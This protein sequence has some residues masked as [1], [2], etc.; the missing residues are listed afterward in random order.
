MKATIYA[1][2]A[3]AALCASA[4][5]A[6]AP[7]R[8]TIQQLAA[9]P[10]FSGF[11]LSPDGAHIAALRG[12]GEQRVIAVWGTD[13][14][15]KAPTLIGSDQMKISGVSFIKNDKLAVSFWQPY[16][17]RTDRLTK[18]FI[19]KLMITDLEGKKWNEPLPV[20][21]SSSR[22]E[23]LRQA[24]TS[25]TVLDRLPND[26]N[27]IL[28]INNVGSS[29]GDIFK[30]D[31]RDFSSER[32]QMSEERVAGYATDLDG[33]VR[34]RLQ[35]NVDSTGA[36]VAAEFRNAQTGA[37][38]EHFR[39]YVKDRDATQIIGFASDPD[40]AFVLSNQGLDKSVVYEYDIVARKKKE[41][42]FG[43]KF[44][45][46]S[47]VL[48][49]P[50]RSA[51]DAFGQ[52]LGFGF[53]GPRGDEMQWTSPALRALDAGLRNALGIKDAKL[54][55][56]DPASGE[57]AAIAHPDQKSY[58]I[59]GYT[60]DLSTLIIGVDGPSLPPEYYLFRNGSLTLLAKSYPGIDARALGE[61]QLVYYT[62]RDGL[63]I[64]AFLTK[65]SQE[66]CGAGPWAAVV[67]PH[68]GPWSRD[69]MDF[70]GSMLVPLMASRCLAVLRPQFR[71]SEGW[72]RKLWMAGDAE[73]GQKMQD[74]KDDGA[75]WL[76]SEG[77]AK[78]ERI[79]MFGF[80]YG[81]YSAF[82]AGVRPN[83]LYKCAIAGAG[84]S[85]IKRIWGRFYTNPFFRQAQA[86]TVAG[87]NPLDQAASLGIPMMVYHGVRDQT[88]PIEQSQWFVQKA[89]ASGQPIV[90]HE[91]EDYA[92]GPAWTRKIMAEQLGYIEDYLVKD[93][94]GGG[95]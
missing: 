86:P 83:G 68:G 32:V 61:T 2:A 5:H 76:V 15:D 57:T 24:R 79:A 29:A 30:V 78:R 11:V 21:R 27:H 19:S 90:Y 69:T 72:G 46:A 54:Q 48:I 66:L 93:C 10:E 44:F 58:W 35:Q 17:L 4:A 82:A 34:A 50:Y 41:V 28:V 36:Y 1:L 23:Q 75:K 81:G 60:A 12:R 64:P 91:I 20:P 49:N 40:T 85:D 56:I 43:H 89:K 37:W 70:D 38:E 51:G 80:S 59:S 31:L 16:D 3:C 47:N 13:A 73:W 14:L 39:S 9:F 87:L 92:H 8:P 52:I 26:P 55:V 25:P 7:Q 71:G 53:N 22:D 63:D 95:L 45:N 42:V 18:T 77:I 65:P 33:N 67:H 62:A 94:G 88:V 84:V 6:A 74:D